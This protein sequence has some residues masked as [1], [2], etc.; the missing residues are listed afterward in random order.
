VEENY[1]IIKSYDKN[2]LVDIIVLS[3]NGLKT[4]Q[5][6]LTHLY[7][8]TLQNMFHLIMV[9]NG[10]TDDTPVFLKD[11]LDVYPNM[12]LILNKNN[13]GVIGGRNLGYNFSEIYRK[14]KNPY[15]MFLDNDQ[16][17]QEGW[18]EQHFHVLNMGY[19]L[20]SVEAWQMNG[21]FMPIQKNTNT[22]Q[23]FSY[24]GAGGMLLKREVSDKIGMF[25][26][27][28]NPAYFEDPDINFR[29]IDAGFKIG[30]NYKAKIVHMPHQTLGKL[31]HSDKTNIFTNSMKK[32]QQK[33]KGRSVPHMFMKEI[34]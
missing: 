15:L 28:F 24:V 9:D 29:A 1:Q 14:N 30:W 25:D 31:N 27:R 21:L 5:E 7:H 4:T 32:F 26:E 17:V 3:H 6:F 18:L 20:I 12:S 16:Y 8:N 23:L 33:W 34:V 22:K 10:S 13:D 11:C 19:D 2:A